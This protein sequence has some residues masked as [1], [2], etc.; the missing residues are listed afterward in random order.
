MDVRMKQM[1]THPPKC[2]LM[3]GHA[4]MSLEFNAVHK[5]AIITTQEKH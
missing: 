5:V 1:D 4:E 3:E 2:L